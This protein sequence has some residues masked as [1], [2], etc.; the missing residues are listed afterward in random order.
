MNLAP[1]GEIV[2]ATTTTFIAQ[3]IE[4]PRPDA[5]AALPDPPAFGT[6]VRIGSA[7]GGAALPADFDPF[8]DAPAPPAEG[9]ALTLYGVVY[10]AET[11]ALETGRSLTAF[12]LEED[13]LRREQPQIYELLA[14]RFSARLVAHTGE[15][16]VPRPYLP[17]RPPRPHARVYVCDPAETR[18][19][20]ERM[21]YL[22][23]LLLDSSGALG[24]SAD[25]L[26]A[27]LLRNA[28]RA[29]SHDETF[30]VR[31]GREV[32]AL[33]PS[34]YDRLRALIARITG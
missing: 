9:G 12:G 21:D 25:E 14:T 33:L 20:T 4:I 8:D 2:A 19:L 30:L 34:D 24:V 23:G 27:A 1:I 7:P 22:R 13:E 6:F 5:V 29:W 3:C 11:G 18:R 32:A 16:G 26:V 17:P 10:F 31:A 15:D 28:W